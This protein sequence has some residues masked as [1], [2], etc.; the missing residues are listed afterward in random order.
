ML[1]STASKLA[2]AVLLLVNTHSYQVD[3]GAFKC[4]EDYRALTDTSSP[5][6]QLQ[7]EAYTDEA[8]LRK[9]G[10]RYCIAL[11]SA[12]G[13]KIGTEYD[14]I[15]GNGSMLPCVLADQ[16]ADADTVRDHTQDR[17]GAVVEFIVDTYRLPE[18]VRQMGDV[19]Y[20]SPEFRGKIK[21]I[22]RAKR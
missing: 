1:T 5:Q 6:Y 16:K 8:G 20:I 3:A 19:S 15:L 13:T 22:R 7:Q 9:V 11:G 4:Y 18:I 10:H 12:Y 21:E 2:V 17:S 14:L